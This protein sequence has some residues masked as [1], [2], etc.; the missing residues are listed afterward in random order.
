MKKVIKSIFYIASV[1]QLLISFILYASSVQYMVII[2]NTIGK[3]EPLPALTEFV[4]KIVPSCSLLFIFLFLIGALKTDK[5][6]NE[7]LIIY[8]SLLFIIELVL[9]SLIGFGY[10]LPSY[11]VM[12]SL[13]S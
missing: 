8:M 9:L 12:W 2:E 10:I 6:K 5:V 11:K 3:D 13:G 4:S 1:L 7:N